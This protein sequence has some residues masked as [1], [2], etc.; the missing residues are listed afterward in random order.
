MAKCKY[1]IISSFLLVSVLFVIGFYYFNKHSNSENYKTQI[2]AGLNEFIL[3]LKFVEKQQFIFES[4][5]LTEDLQLLNINGDSVNLKSILDI[6]KQFI[7]ISS[8]YYCTCS[9]YLLEYLNGFSKELDSSRVVILQKFN[10]IREMQ[11]LRKRFKHISFYQLSDEKS[12]CFNILGDQYCLGILSYKGRIN[13]VFIPLKQDKSRTED[14]LN[15]LK[16]K[17]SN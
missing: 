13:N 11:L 15:I 17:H 2:E 1:F 4:T 7:A 16:E 5:E 12:S 8:G 10:G 6:E 9:E 3:D 14:Y